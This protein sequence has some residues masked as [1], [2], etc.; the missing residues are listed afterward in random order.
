M[1]SKRIFCVGFELPGEE[2]EYVEFNSDRSLLDADIVLFE[3]GFGEPPSEDYHGE[4]LFSHSA[5]T[6]VIKNLLH[7]RSELSS[8]ANAGKLVVIFL[9]RP[10]RAHVYTGKQGF[11]GT[12]RSRV[13]TNYVT[14]IESYSAVPSVT[15]AEAK[16]GR[17]VRLTQD[18]AFLS[19]YWMEFSGKSEYEAFIEG[20]FTK[21]VLTTKTGGKVVGALVKGK[22]SLLL[23]PPIR[24]DESKFT[25]Y[26]AKKQETY[27]TADA[28]QYGKRLV[29]FLV[30]LANN[31]LFGGSATIPP[32][33][34][35]DGDFR[36][37]EEAGL[38]KELAEIGSLIV[39]LQQRRDA[40]RSDLILAGSSR[41]L[42]F[43]QGP[44]LERAVVDAL[45]V[46]GFSATRYAEE[47]SEFDA[48][49][50][51]PEGRFLGEVEGKDT[52]PLNI[53]KFSQLE[54]NL[55][56]DFARE[57]V[58]TYAKGV[59]FGN[60]ERLTNPAERKEPFT[61][62]CL[63]AAKR[64]HV[65]L[66][67]TADLFAPIRYLKASPNPAYATACR[68]AIYAADGEVVRFPTPPVSSLSETAEAKINAPALGT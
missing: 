43:E 57:E 49:F 63:S 56:E 38:E 34:V 30:E 68:E 67:R 24:Y 60:A 5:S 46:M 19:P 28:E 39:S 16:T 21:T 12:G 51:S 62:K 61:Q 36:L 33:W 52:K 4:P 55:Q 42:L 9:A 23:I 50:E 45:R 47:G 64:V 31:L 13:T 10:R 11:S 48:V 20:E 25:K 44:R 15:S 54:R 22:G 41:A 26:N 29:A 65:A 7:W 14:E 37:P 35:E 27:W 40:L 66:V 3:P 18:G 2:F 6:R 17:E 59:L 32:K 8:A 53:E 58:Q 1:P